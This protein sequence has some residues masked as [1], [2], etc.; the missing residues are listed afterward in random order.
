[1]TISDPMAKQT[2]AAS[3]LALLAQ[4]VQHHQCTIEEVDVSSSASPGGHLALTV[5][6][7]VV[8]ASYKKA[9]DSPDRQEWLVAMREEF[10]DLVSR[11]TWTL[12]DFLQK[13]GSENP[14]P[15]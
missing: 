12:V 2:T 15:T 7:V 8:P 13:T 6:D 3:P 1:M 9:L 10:Q 11:Q 4:P 14:K 5:V